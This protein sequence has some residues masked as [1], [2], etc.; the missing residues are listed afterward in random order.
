MFTK[1]AQGMPMVHLIGVGIDLTWK[2]TRK[3]RYKTT[4]VLQPKVSKDS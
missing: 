4:V 3:K 1:V 2:T